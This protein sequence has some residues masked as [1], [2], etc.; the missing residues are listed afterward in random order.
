[1]SKKS[2]APR[3]SEGIITTRDGANNDAQ[4]LRLLN[5]RL[6]LL[7]RQFATAQSDLTSVQAALDSLKKDQ[8]RDLL[9]HAISPEHRQMRTFLGFARQHESKTPQTPTFTDR[10]AWKKGRLYDQK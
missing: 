8:V 5:A 10:E 2:R 1:M 6:A 3:P 9:A 4:L 7:S